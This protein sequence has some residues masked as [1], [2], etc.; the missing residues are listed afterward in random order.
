MSTLKRIKDGCWRS[1]V[2]GMRLHLQR[3][4]GA[5]CDEDVKAAE[6][7]FEDLKA[8]LPAVCFSGRFRY[9]SND[10]LEERTGLLT[11][12]VDD[13]S[14][15]DINGIRERAMTCPHVF[16]SFVS[17]SGRGY[18][19]VVRVDATG[20][21][22]PQWWAACEMVRSWGFSVGHVDKRCSDVARL[23]FVSYDPQT[24]INPHAIPL[25][26]NWEDVPEEAPNDGQRQDQLR[27]PRAGKV[28]Q[29]NGE[30]EAEKHELARRL[31][32]CRMAG[33]TEHEAL[34]QVGNHPEA[35]RMVSGLYT[36]P[37]R[38]QLSAEQQQ[39]LRAR[40]EREGLDGFRGGAATSLPTWTQEH[41]FYR[42][43]GRLTQRLRYAG[44][45]PD[46][47]R[48]ALIVITH[49]TLNGVAPAPTLAAVRSCV[50]LDRQPRPEG[51][52][53]NAESYLDEKLIRDLSGLIT[54]I[55]RHEGP[56]V[57]R[58][59]LTAP[60]G[61][62]ERLARKYPETGGG[63]RQASPSI[64]RRVAG[65]LMRLAPE[66]TGEVSVAAVVEL[67]QLRSITW[68]P[69]EFRRFLVP[70]VKSRLHDTDSRWV[71]RTLR[72]LGLQPPAPRSGKNA[73]WLLTPEAGAI[74]RKLI[75]PKGGKKGLDADEDHTHVPPPCS[76]CAPSPQDGGP[77][78]EILGPRVG[79]IP[80]IGTTR[81]RMGPTRPTRIAPGLWQVKAVTKDGLPTFELRPPEGS[82]ANA[83]TLPQTAT[84]LVAGYHAIAGRNGPRVYARGLLP[85]W[86]VTRRVNS[87]YE[88][89]LC[90][91]ASTL[92]ERFPD[93]IPSAQVLT[94]DLPATTPRVGNQLWGIAPAGGE[95]P[96]LLLRARD[97]VE[98]LHPLCGKA[99]AM[100]A[101]W[102]QTHETA[103]RRARQV[104]EEDDRVA[105]LERKAHR[106][107]EEHAELAKLR[108][109]AELR[110]GVRRRRRKDTETPIFRSFV[111]SQ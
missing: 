33:M 59:S 98:G 74:V 97:D 85:G 25:H 67:L 34:T 48:S 56:D 52:T 45:S 4:S 107:K 44:F 51:L 40:I 39:A 9:R 11:V 104:R 32:Y 1:Q 21:H 62:L 22:W 57:L 79:A 24:H 17:P 16:G 18:K 15:D 5:S 47:I 38:R 109:R 49:H 35:R 61:D 111:D 8:K 99:Y 41:G 20:R 101:R 78:S 110:S 7:V 36:M 27:T 91:P 105:T 89:E 76:P 103:E 92:Q 42:R 81:K 108:A 77:A 86:G 2:E 106:S 23:S 88:V 69:D 12:D 50:G 14:A 26:I 90:L 87:F 71:R 19:I 37:L 80:V 58:W 94:S 102:K 29:H 66:L 31:T 10:G 46:H 30:S 84:V 95:H 75:H 82:K 96:Y 43:W 93:L 6:R 72:E 83:I 60:N 65:C 70:E 73:R 13:L 53:H 100:F 68:Q 55:V 63:R 64:C 3:S 28:P 54:C